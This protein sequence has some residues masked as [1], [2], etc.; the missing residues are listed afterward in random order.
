MSHSV[1]LSCA[2]HRTMAPRLILPEP[3]PPI[4]GAWSPRCALQRGLRDRRRRRWKLWR[5][6]LRR[7][8]R[9][10]QPAAV[11]RG[12]SATWPERTAGPLDGV[13]V[14][15]IGPGPGGLTRALLALGASLVIAIECDERAIAAIEEI[16][17]HYPGRLEIIAADALNFDPR[18]HSPF[19]R[20]R[21]VANLPYNIAT[22]LLVKWLSVDPWPPWFDS[23]VLMFQREV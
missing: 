7:D 8:V 10:R 23:A 21:I 5:R 16:A 6:R 20:A 11:T 17:A 3:A 4:R 15:E 14:L 9:L 12:H 22:A 19:D 2:P 18:A 1:F 13:T